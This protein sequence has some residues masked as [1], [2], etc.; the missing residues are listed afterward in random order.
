MSRPDPFRQPLD[1]TL[2]ALRER[3]PDAYRCTPDPTRWQADCP[4]CN[5]HLKLELREPFVGA[6]VLATCAEG[7][8]PERIAEALATAPDDRDATIVQ[9]HDR[10]AAL[11]R[12][13]HGLRDLAFEPC[14]LCADER[15]AA[16]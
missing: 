13:I 15:E 14:P 3:G 11:T 8:H 10:V 6:D 1:A 9:L 2:L 12:L 16:A 7:C 4:A 5:G